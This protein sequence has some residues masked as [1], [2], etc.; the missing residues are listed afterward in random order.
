MPRG[1]QELRTLARTAATSLRGRVLIVDVHG[2]VLVD[3]AGPAQLGTSYDSRP[4][5]R[6]ALS[7]RPLQVERSSR[8]LGQTILATAVPII[9]NRHTV[10]AVRVTQSIAAVNGAVRRAVLGLIAIGA[11][12]LSARP[13]RG[14]GHRGPGGTADQAPRPGRRRVAQGDL[15][16][17]AE[18]EGSREQ[19]SLANSFNEMTG[20]IER[21]LSAQ[22]EF[23]ADASH[24][25]RTPVTGL[26]LRLEAAKAIGQTPAGDVELD[27][28]VA[29]VDRLAQT[30]EELLV[31][32][33]AGERRVTG[34]AVDLADVAVAVCR[35]WRVA[36]A[37][38]RVRL[39]C[40]HETE[41]DPVWAA[42][43]D[44]D[45]ALDSLVENAIN[46]SPPD[47]TIEIQSTPWRIEVRDRGPGLGEDERGAVFERFHR[48]K[49]GLAG[50]PGSGLGLPIARE[51]ARGW[52]GDVTIENRDGGGAVA[53]LA[54]PRRNDTDPSL[55]RLNSDVTTVTR[56]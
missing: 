44:V 54:L 55:P 34:A 53:I 5:I 42:R 36:A 2:D 13:L 39:V 48:G 14:G 46:Y 50:P 28:A 11:V 7:G 51:L 17:R 56:S 16:A 38:R 31:L 47:S 21:L 20:R 37:R 25:L 15:T 1:R 9:R 32:S 40:R 52:S 23:V 41:M 43:P 3:S 22:R 4:E 24:E 19:R 18:V 30:V 8:T 45:R 49:A 10:G 26:R 6:A 33:R 29:E 35:R 12:V 27:A